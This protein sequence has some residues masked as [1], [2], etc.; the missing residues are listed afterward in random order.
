MIKFANIKIYYLVMFII[1][2][3][4]ITNNSVLEIINYIS[5]HKYEF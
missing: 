2:T 1:L 4:E 5:R 3:I